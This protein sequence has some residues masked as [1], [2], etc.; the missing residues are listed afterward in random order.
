MRSLGDARGERLRRGVRVCFVH[1]PGRTATVRGVVLGHG[2]LLVEVETARGPRFVLPDAVQTIGR[3]ARD[4]ARER[5][6]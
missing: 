6:V 2:R 3:E 4:G 1:E 5:Q